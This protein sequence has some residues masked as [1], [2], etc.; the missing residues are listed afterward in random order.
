MAS[1]THA[2]G[3]RGVADCEGPNVPGQRQTV[4]WCVSRNCASPNNETPPGKDRRRIGMASNTHAGGVA[5]CEEPNVPGQRQT[6]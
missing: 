4:W 1:N 2:G 6:V 5:D 3:A